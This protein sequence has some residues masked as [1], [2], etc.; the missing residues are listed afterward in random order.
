[1]DTMLSILSYPAGGGA[2]ELVIGGASYGPRGRGARIGYALADSPCGRMLLAATMHGVCW[3]GIHAEDSF[4]IGEL[5]RDLALAEIVD[6]STEARSALDNILNYCFKLAGLKVSLDIIAQ[7]FQGRVWRELCQIPCGETRSYGEI[8]RRLGQPSA[9]RAVGH[10]NGSN[11]LAVLIPC[12]R[13]LGADGRLTGYRWGLDY[14]RR[15]L[16]FERS[17][18]AQ[19]A[20]EEPVAAPLPFRLES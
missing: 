14:K 7:P 10:A 1:M 12:H 11:P 15:L 5:R 3:I 6:E 20:L 17:Q 8:A 2:G 9:A 19:A 18:V 13:A 16:E 4:L